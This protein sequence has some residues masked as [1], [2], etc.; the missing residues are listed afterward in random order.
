MER[1]DEAKRQEEAD[2]RRLEILRLQLQVNNSGNTSNLNSVNSNSV[3]VGFGNRIPNSFMPSF[4]E[5][6]DKMDSYIKRFE[7]IALDNNW[8]PDTWSRHFSYLLTGKSLDIYTEMNDQDTADWQLL[9]DALLQKFKLTTDGYRMQYCDDRPLFDKSC[10]QFIERLLQILGKWLEV[11]GLEKNYENLADI[12]VVEKFLSTCPKDLAISL[13][14]RGVRGH[15]DVGISADMYL[16]AHNRSLFQKSNNHNNKNSNNN[17]RQTQKSEG[18]NNASNSS[19]SKGVVKC[20][21]C[22]KLGHRANVCRSEKKNYSDRKNN[23]SSNTNTNKPTVA[24]AQV[25]TSQPPESNENCLFDNS[26]NKFQYVVNTCLSDSHPNLP[27]A[28]G[29][30][31]G[32][33]VTCLRDSGCNSVIVKKKFVKPNQ[34]TGTHAFMVRVDNTVISAPLARF[35]VDTPYF[36]GKVQAS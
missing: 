4:N 18:G 8:S 21:N 35:S 30:L 32:S 12:M 25:I 1:E 5:K 17:N 24:V 10:S 19:D 16:R 28:L 23:S 11:S 33:E 14:E 2:N 22:N 7:R 13:R 9:K 20:Y 36:K 15:K 3:N 26:G 34:Y 6:T 27:T 29:K 31:N